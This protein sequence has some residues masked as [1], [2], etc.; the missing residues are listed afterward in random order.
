MKTIEQDNVKFEVDEY[1]GCLKRIYN[2]PPDEDKD[3]YIPHVLHDGTEIN[4]LGYEFCATATIGKLTVDNAISKIDNG[5]FRAADCV[6]V[7][8][9][10]SCNIIPA[11]CFRDSIVQKLTN[12]DHVTTIGTAAFANCG[13]QE[14]TWPSNCNV[15]PEGC[16]HGTPLNKIENL[17]HVTEVEDLA[18]AKIKTSLK[19]DLSKGTYPPAISDSAFLSSNC[20]VELPYYFSNDVDAINVAALSKK[21]LRDIRKNSRENDLLFKLFRLLP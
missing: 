4:C 12:I 13:M 11:D 7:V 3:V 14:F 9:P 20:E 10:D 8:W 21:S 6:E 18:F 19:I 2:C 15:I 5:A 1:S 17:E 16:F